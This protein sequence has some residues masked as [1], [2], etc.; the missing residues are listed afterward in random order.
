MGGGVHAKTQ[1]P[2]DFKAR[3]KAELERRKERA[4]GISRKH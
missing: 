1:N 4:R 3:E 2:V